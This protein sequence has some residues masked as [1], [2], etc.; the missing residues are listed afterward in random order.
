MEG[1]EEYAGN[2][3]K[4]SALNENF[5]A[6]KVKSIEDE[7]VLETLATTPDLITVVNLET[8]M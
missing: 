6:E 8:S 7:E 1:L 5:V 4:I 3:V 2:F